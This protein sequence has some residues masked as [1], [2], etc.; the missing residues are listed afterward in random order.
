V[1]FRKLGYEPQ[2]LS[3][4]VGGESPDTLR[5]VLAAK[6]VTLPGMKISERDMR[7]MHWIEDFY[8]RRTRGI[9]TYITR[10]D[11][12]DRR[13]SRISDALR[14]TPGIHFVRVRGGIGVRFVSSPIHRRDCVPMIWLDGQ[15]APEMEVDELPVNEIEGIE[16]Y[17]GPSTTPMQF[18]QGARTTCGTIVVWSRVPGT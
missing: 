10:E 4:T 17:H 13:A 7:R 11:I 14:N 18:S 1:S 3:H 16:L 15:R 12:E 2:T 8:R 9:G 5:V 6:V